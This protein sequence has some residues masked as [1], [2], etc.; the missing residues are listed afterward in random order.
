M[1]TGRIEGASETD[2][3]QEQHRADHNRPCK[4]HMR[5]LYYPSFICHVIALRVWR[6]TPKIVANSLQFLVGVTTSDLEQAPPQ[7]DRDCMGPV[8]CA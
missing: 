6:N 7:R 5:R 4:I 3:Q 8:I 1:V 2:G